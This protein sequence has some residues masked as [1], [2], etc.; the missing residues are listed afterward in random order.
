[1]LLTVSSGMTASRSTSQK[2]ATLARVSLSIGRSER[3]AMMS[4]WMPM[5]RS[6]RTLC[7]VGLVLSS[8]LAFR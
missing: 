4:G 6:S 7:W 5:P 8:P 1:M 3:S 2:S